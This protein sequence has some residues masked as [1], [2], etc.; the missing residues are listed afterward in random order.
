MPKTPKTDLRKS[1]NPGT[2]DK[3]QKPNHKIQV[4]LSDD[5]YNKLIEMKDFLG[6]S[7]Y[8]IVIRELIHTAICYRVDYDGLFELSTQIAR[9]GNNINQIALA[10]NQS[11]SITPYQLHTL[12]QQMDKI[13]NILLEAT[14]VKAHVQKMLSEEFF[15]GGSNGDNEDH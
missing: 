3:E 7:T 1:E 12:K 15:M 9:V 11:K 14:T 8:A 5:E 10:C 4:I 6:C 2:I 13:E